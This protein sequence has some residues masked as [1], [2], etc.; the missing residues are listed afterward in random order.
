MQIGDDP[1]T[2]KWSAAMMPLGN[3]EGGRREEVESGS[4]AVEIPWQNACDGQAGLYE[5][6]PLHPAVLG[7]IFY[8]EL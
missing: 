2:V 6:I 8:L 4:L 1:V 7:W 3:W 5:R